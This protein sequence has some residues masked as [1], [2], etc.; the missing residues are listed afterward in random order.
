MT[1]KKITALKSTIFVMFCLLSLLTIPVKSISQPTGTD[2]TATKH[3]P[4]FIATTTDGNKISSGSLKGKVVLLNFYYIGC[5]PFMKEIAALN[6][7]YNEFKSDNFLLLSIAPH[8]KKSIEE[9]NNTK[10]QSANVKSFKKALNIPKMEYT[11]AY[12]CENDIPLFKKTGRRKYR[13]SGP[14]C[15]GEIDSLFNIQY[16]PQ[17]FLIDRNGNYTKAKIIMDMEGSIDKKKLDDLKNEIR[18]MLKD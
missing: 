12:E 14:Q 7:I 3:T 17:S 4:S 2:S 5:F 10:R 9:F 1:S 16:Y 13:G 18:A 8:N 6:E 15:N 11:L